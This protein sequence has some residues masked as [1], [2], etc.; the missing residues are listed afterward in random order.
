MRS[1]FTGGCSSDASTPPINRVVAAFAAISVQ[2]RSTASAGIRLMA[3][4]H[5]IDRLP[6]DLQRR[7]VQ[8]AL[9]EHR[10]IAR[11]MQQQI[12]IAQRHVQ[13]FGETQH[14]VAAWLRPAG[15]QKAQMPRGDFRFERQLELAQA[16]ALAPLAQQITH[17]SDRD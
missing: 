1:T 10:R 7:I 4:E 17:R 15:F 2:C 8:R 5:L 9:R 11:R 12:A 16:T 13:L 6:R 14:H 3:G